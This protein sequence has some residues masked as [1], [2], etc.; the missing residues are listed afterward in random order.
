VLRDGLLEEAAA[1]SGERTFSA[2]VERA[3]EDLIRR[4][5]ARQILTLTGSG[6]WEGDLA[7]MRGDARR[8]RRRR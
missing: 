1:L 5:K 4:H 7:A 3:L 2:T 6:G 8:R